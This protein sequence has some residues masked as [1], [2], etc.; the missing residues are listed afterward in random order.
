MPSSIYAVWAIAFL[1]VP[2][3]PLLSIRPKSW[4]IPISVKKEPLSINAYQICKYNMLIFIISNKRIAQQ[5]AILFHGYVRTISPSSSRQTGLDHLV[6]TGL[7][8]HRIILW[9]LG[10]PS[11]HPAAPNLDRAQVISQVR[12]WI[13]SGPSSDHLAVPC[14]NRRRF[15][16]QRQI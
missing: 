12:T 13:A 6:E 2:A 7:C 15:I 14:P 8:S 5:C 10:P 4:S 9:R 16:L 3:E 1:K 11:D